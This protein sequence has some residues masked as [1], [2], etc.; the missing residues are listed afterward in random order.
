MIIIFIIDLFLNNVLYLPC[1]LIISYLAFLKKSN[2]LSYFTI[3]IFI[4]LYYWHSLTSYL[5]YVSLILFINNIF[6]KNKGKL[7]IIL[8]DYL[9]FYLLLGLIYSSLDIILFIK[10]YFITY[11]LA[12]VI[13]HILPK[14]NIKLFW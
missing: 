2:Y 1:S 14:Y 3:S 12:L 9:I 4:S 6:L 10:I 11:I 8:V 7:F 5:F 13:Y